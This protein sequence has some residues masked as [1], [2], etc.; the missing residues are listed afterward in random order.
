MSDH[1]K[2]SNSFPHIITIII[3]TID[4]IS[5][6]EAHITKKYQLLL[7]HPFNSLFQDNLGKPAPER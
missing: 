5:G 7:V 3:V 1:H 6:N 4:F 2:I